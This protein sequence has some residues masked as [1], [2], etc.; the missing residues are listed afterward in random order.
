M[1]D[2]RDGSQSDNRAL[3]DNDGSLLLLGSFAVIGVLALLFAGGYGIVALLLDND[4]ETVAG[5]DAPIV[6]APLDDSA[7]QVSE[8]V[9][10]VAPTPAPTEPTLVTIAQAETPAPVVTTS[11]PR[12]PPPTTPPVVTSNTDV[13]TTTPPSSPA[14][15]PITSTESP[16]VAEPP[17][18]VPEPVKPASPDKPP[19]DVVASAKPTPEPN[20]PATTETPPATTTVKPEVEKPVK[21]APPAPALPAESRP[22][23]YNWA[24]GEI[25]SYSVTLSTDTGGNEQIVTGNVELTIQEGSKQPANVA[26]A[27][28]DED[29]GNDTEIG[30]GTG[31]VVS[32]DGYLM[33]CAHVVQGANRIEV[34]IGDQKYEAAVIAVEPDDD[35]ALLR[36]DAQGLSPLGLADSDQVKLGEEI[37]AVGFPLSSVLGDGVKVTKGT[38]AGIVQRKE[39]KRLQIDAAINP[40]NSGGPIINSRGQVLGIASSKLIG[41][42][43]TGVG[44]CVPSERASALMA[45]HQ[46]KPATVAVSDTDLSGPALVEAVSPSVALITVSAE[47]IK[48]TGEL[49]VIR[50]SGS[51]RTKRQQNAGRRIFSPFASLANYTFDRGSLR[52]DSNGHVA[53]FDA[54]NQLPFLAGPMALLAVHQFDPHGRSSWTVRESITVTIQESDNRFGPGMRRIPIPRLP[55]GFGGP[56]GG[57][58]L[59]PFA[60]REVKKLTAVEVHQYRIK[61][62]S[63]DE[64]L[65]E[66][67]FSLTT[68]D[69]EQNPYFHINGTGEVKFSRVSGLVESFEFDHNFTQNGG[70]KRIRVPVKIKVEREPPQVVAKRKR[71]LAIQTA[72]TEWTNAQKAAEK[73]AQPPGERLDEILVRLHDEMEK[74]G[75]KP[76]GPIGELSKLKVIPERK[77]EVEKLLTKQLVSEDRLVRVD[78]I[79]ALRVWGTSESVPELIGL[80]TS[81]DR[82]TA[83]G[84]MATLGAIG[85][86]RAVVPL[87]DK[88]RDISM[89]RDA[90]QA[91][92]KLGAP[93]EE[94]V[95]EKMMG[96]DRNT[97]R[98]LCEI[99]KTIGGEASLKVLEEMVAGKDFF[100]RTYASRAIG[101]VRKRVEAQKALAVPEGQTLSN[102]DVQ[103]ATSLEVLN[104]PDSNDVEKLNALTALLPI[105]PSDFK[106]DEIEVKLNELL[107][108]PGADIRK[109][110]LTLLG[111]W[112]T[113]ASAPGLLKV[114]LTPDPAQQTPALQILSRIGTQAEADKL[115]ELVIDPALYQH[116][117]ALVR[118]TGLGPAAEQQLSGFLQQ[119]VP[120]STKRGLIDLLGDIGTAASLVALDAVA[121]APQA[122]TLQYAAAKAAAKVRLRTGIAFNS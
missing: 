110:S 4:D 63:D 119:D 34:Q 35:L 107:E 27:T 115:V 90:Q 10:P 52:V 84:A 97:V 28:D 17:A 33:T 74:E 32:A 62:D 16:G 55:R 22:L 24:P 106:R 5:S 50:T 105:E 44:F 14:N 49:V 41:L 26:Q 45:A 86:N 113:D 47:S 40:G 118:R 96:V 112:A 71:D 65:L 54:P 13:A 8:V 91:L 82:Q 102:A 61:S 9:P 66:K 117:I 103:V 79:T 88:L 122:S 6:V 29:E 7:T 68:L 67:T 19:G 20:S 89:Q 37:R 70:G 56:R 21:P 78:T 3:K 38:I 43:L 31:F 80:I 42:E 57:R 108:Y 23:V 53:S 12:E 30:T 114:A 95:L 94:A 81:K 2:S 60:P 69:D 46:V 36:I 99:L 59:N 72:K 98:V 85:D 18:S 100:Q 83:T 48:A 76:R 1:S 73:A 121:D 101:S 58:G 75:G 39:G 11:E 92:G 64:V 120:V 109:Q 111:K 77:A 15:P 104:K 93:A 116:P 87:L 51:F 25:Q